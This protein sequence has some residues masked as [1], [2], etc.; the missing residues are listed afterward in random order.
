M[1]L[2]LP[3]EMCTR[4]VEFL[5]YT[6]HRPRRSTLDGC[7]SYGSRAVTQRSA[8]ALLIPAK[9]AWLTSLARSVSGIER[10]VLV[11][12]KDNVG[13]SGNATGTGWAT[14]YLG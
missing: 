5:S 6:V 13:S 10:L 4:D 2:E 7:S 11:V 12:E 9:R 8:Q 14:E 1:P 3:V